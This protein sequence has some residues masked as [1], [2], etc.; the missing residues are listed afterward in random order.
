M[1]YASGDA[2][3]LMTF[4]PILNGLELQ[5]PPSVVYKGSL[6]FKSNVASVVYLF[7]Y[8]W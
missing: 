8:C 2:S 6:C 5:P 4:N 1:R 7:I 3:K